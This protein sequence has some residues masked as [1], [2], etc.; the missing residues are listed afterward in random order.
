MVNMNKDLF[1]EKA[2]TYEKNKNRVDNVQNIAIA[3]LDSEDGSFHGEAAG[4]FH[5][6]FDREAISGA[7]RS[8]GFNDVAVTSASVVHKENRDYP[9][10]LLSGRC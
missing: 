3:D 10:F 8:A 1:A 7:A 4:V 9:A 6:G 5:K 2:G